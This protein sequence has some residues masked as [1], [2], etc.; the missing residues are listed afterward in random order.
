V[1]DSRT[2]SEIFGL[3]DLRGRIRTIRQLCRE[4]GALMVEARDALAATAFDIDEARQ[5]LKERGQWETLETRQAELTEHI[6]DLE[7][8]K[9]DLAKWFEEGIADADQQIAKLGEELSNLS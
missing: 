2:V 8:H 6:D 9:R 4:S 7:Y 3:G 1:S 5:L